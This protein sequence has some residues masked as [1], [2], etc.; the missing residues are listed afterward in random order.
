MLKGVL[1]ECMANMELLVWC[2]MD[3]NRSYPTTM[4]D[5][6][7]PVYE[8]AF[9]SPDFSHW[10]AWLILRIR[11][12][13]PVSEF[14]NLGQF[15]KNVDSLSLASNRWAPLLPAE[16]AALSEVAG[17]IGVVEG[18]HDWDFD[19]HY[20]WKAARSV[21]EHLT[22]EREVSYRHW[23]SGQT[24]AELQFRLPFAMPYQGRQISEF[25]VGREGQ[26][27]DILHMFPTPFVP[28]R[29]QQVATIASLPSHF[30][31]SVD[32]TPTR[33]L[34]QNWANIL[35]FTTTSSNCC[36][37]GYRIFTLYFQPVS[38]MLH[39]SFSS[40]DGS[41]HGY[42]DLPVLAAGR[43]TTVLVRVGPTVIEMYVG[44]ARVLHDDSIGGDAGGPA[45]DVRVYAS[46]TFQP[47][48]HVAISKLA[49]RAPPITNAAVADEQHQ[50]ERCWARLTAL[51]PTPHLVSDV[52][53][54]ASSQGAAYFA[55]RFCPG[56]AKYVS[57]TACTESEPD[58][59]AAGNAAFDGG[60]D[61]YDIGEG[62]AS[63][64]LL[65]FAFCSIVR[66]QSGKYFAGNFM[67]TSLMGSCGEDLHGCPLGSLTY[68]D[69]LSRQRLAAS[70]R[71]VSTV[72]FGRNLFGSSCRTMPA[73]IRWMSL[74]W[75]TSGLT[76]AVQ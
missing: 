8:P 5:H 22:A 39:I 28:K 63:H 58:C 12:H 59:D 51:V 4:T 65:F 69:D 52:E 45:T 49:V 57:A 7:P 47:A 2:W 72:C 74:C 40:N 30:E 43:P 17:P 42:T 68:R 53:T 50:S 16:K 19:F 75:A 41:L 18:D 66:S 36:R 24:D 26:F 60:D 3:D 11:I 21:E 38:L 27:Q 44:G 34:V 55:E 62:R 32:V 46:D 67:V 54:T 37:P 1:P 15:L 70:V 33:E 20:E 29:G 31:V 10:I 71:A 73:T 9:V 76:A 35:R 56:W 23:T 48:A 14:S 25:S 64:P 61:M 13:G 6:S